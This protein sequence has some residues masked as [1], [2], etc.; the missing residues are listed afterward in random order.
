MP[1]LALI[2]LGALFAL[3]GCGDSKDPGESP[4]GQP[5]LPST[6]EAKAPPLGPTLRELGSGSPIVFCDRLTVRFLVENYM[7]PAPLALRTCRRE[8]RRDIEVAR[9]ELE[10]DVVNRQKGRAIITL[11]VSGSPGSYMAL[12]SDGSRWL[13]DGIAPTEELLPGPRRPAL[14]DGISADQ[15]ESFILVQHES[16]VRV[17]C[18][19]VE[20]QDLGEW[21]C[22]MTHVFRRRGPNKG[23]VV[24]TVAPNGAVSAAGFGAGSRI[25]GCCIEL[26]AE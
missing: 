18:S 11:S 22:D 19:E 21:T 26:A 10:L 8:A 14:T 13:I 17:V 24:V 20:N 12:I 6:T 2:A 25:A 3:T 5:A 9:D 16:A 7:K 15:L 23:F 1:R 4:A